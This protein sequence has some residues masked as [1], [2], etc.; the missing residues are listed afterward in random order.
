MFLLLRVII[1]ILGAMLVGF[2]L[3]SAVR[4]LVLP[5]A[6]P[7]TIYGSVF[8]LVRWIFD[9]RLRSV[10]SF[11]ARD[12][13]MA[14][15]A[16]IALL[17]LLPVWLILVTLGYAGMYWA[18][19]MPT[20]YE[21]F[22]LSGSSLLT[23]GF[24]KAA[25]FWQ[26]NLVFSE[27]TFGLLLIALLIAYLPSMYSAFQRRAAAVSLLEVRAGTPPSAVEM[28]LRFNR[29]HGIDRLSD[30]WRAWETWFADLQESHSSLPALVFFR[31][32][33]PEN[34]WITAAG[35]VLDAAALSRST[36]DIPQ[37]FE[38]DL[39]IR[40]GYLAL[41]HIAD[42]FRIDYNPSPAPDDPISITRAEFDAAYEQF[43]DNGVP[44]LPDQDQAWRDFAG[45][46]V[47]YDQVLIELAELVMAPPAPWSSDRNSNNQSLQN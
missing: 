32:P 1:F 29:I 11:Q 15:Y 45:W 31:A 22:L 2:T 34:S 36:L 41:R 39:C 5:R 43:T 4:T 14:Y 13:I 42:Y 20:W 37:D 6:A 9:L 24:A 18:L 33:Q 3:L 46:R 10:D 7:D 47:N 38:A 30:Q 26:L 17:T 35:T 8:R 19:G 23:L 40:A 44:V 25:D 27:A 21:A 28:L 12:Q 16:P